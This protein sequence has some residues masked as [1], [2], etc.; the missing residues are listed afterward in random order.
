MNYLSV[1]L[2][3]E[4]EFTIYIAIY[5]YIDPDQTA[6]SRNSDIN[7]VR[8]FMIQIVDFKWIS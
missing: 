6:A 1:G 2:E 4:N 3:L 8:I 5:L 7:L